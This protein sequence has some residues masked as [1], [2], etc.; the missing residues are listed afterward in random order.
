MPQVQ[1]PSF[2]GQ[3]TAGSVSTNYPFG[4]NQDVQNAV[5]ATAAVIV[6]AGTITTA[7]VSVARVAPA[8]AVTGVILEEGTFDGQMV[9][10]SNES[11]AADSVTFAAAATSNVA[12]GTGAV[13][14]GNAKL[15]LMWSKALSL[16]L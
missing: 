1:I 16:W 12:A 8:G 4:V 3:T 10:V 5:S 2:G 13:I 9:I 14:A 15:Q 7:G 11:A 6:S